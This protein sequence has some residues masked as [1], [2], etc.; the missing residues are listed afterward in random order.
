VAEAERL[1]QALAANTIDQVRLGEQQPETDHGLRFEKSQ[2]GYGPLGK[3][4]R[5][6]GEDGWFSFEMKTPPVSAKA[7]VRLVFWGRDN[8]PEFDVLVDGKVIATAKVQA[9]GKDDYYGVE[10]PVPTGSSEP[11]NTVTV[12]IQTKPGKNAA[13]IYDLRIVTIQ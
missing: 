2:T 12:K 4:F 11:R 9:T 1:E 8:G 5:A 10:Y 13:A 3:H 7:A 6:L